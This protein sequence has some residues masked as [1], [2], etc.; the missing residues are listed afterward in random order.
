MRQ[1]VLIKLELL[2]QKHLQILGQQL[3]KLMRELN[4]FYQESQSILKDFKLFPIEV[5]LPNTSL[6]LQHE[7]ITN[8]FAQSEYKDEEEK[9]GK[10]DGEIESELLAEFNEF[11]LKDEQFNLL[12]DDQPDDQSENLINF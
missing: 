6:E 9:C 7:S 2:E 12:H 8:P 11:K 10:D 5:D 3:Q 1:D 4:K